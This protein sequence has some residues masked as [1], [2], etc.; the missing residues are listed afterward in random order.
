MVVALVT[1]LKEVRA[2]NSALQ[3]QQLT[4]FYPMENSSLS[5]GY[6]WRP[7]QRAGA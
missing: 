5:D 7:R 2:L 6:Y 1:Y 3:I 4:Y